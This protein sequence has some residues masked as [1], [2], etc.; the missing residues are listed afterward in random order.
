MGIR[1]EYARREQASWVALLAQFGRLDAAEQVREGVVPGWSARDLIWHCARWAEETAGHLEQMRAGT[2]VDPFEADETLGD[3]MNDEIA[4]QARTMSVED[5]LEASEVCRAKLR[6]VWPT[7]EPDEQAADW[8]A[9]ET[10]V[11][12]DEHAAEIAAFADRLG[13]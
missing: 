11:H 6:V 2:F 5:V 1:G 13:A 4:A 8:Y 7:V 10:F 12:Y 3:R 9:E